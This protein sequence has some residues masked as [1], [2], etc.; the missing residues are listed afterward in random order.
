MSVGT[1]LAIVAHPDDIEFTVAGTLLLLKDIG[2]NIHFWNL[3]NGCY[4]SMAYGKAEITRIR[5]MEAAEAAARAGATYH[6]AIVDDLSILYRPELIAKVT[7]V[8][9]DV[10]PQIIITHSLTDYMEDHQN[11]ARLAVTGAFIRAAPNFV[12]DPPQPAWAGPTLIYHAMPHGLHGPMREKVQPELYVDVGSVLARKSAL[13][14][15]HRSQQAWLEATQAMGSIVEEAETY[16]L[17][18]GKISGRFTYAEGY[19]RH[20]H[21]GFA[22]AEAD[23]LGEALADKV[24]RDPAYLR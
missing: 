1:A 12:S 3:A 14:A 18:I 13:L 10:K 15:C 2:W 5:A 23:P 7:A 17:A 19:R 22:G 9:R 6:P 20:L 8:V 11:A 16:A 24:W 4:G 21:L